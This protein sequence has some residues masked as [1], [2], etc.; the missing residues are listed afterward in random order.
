[1]SDTNLPDEGHH[2]ISPHHNA[3]GRFARGNQAGKGHG[4]PVA[5]ATI[6]LRQAM[7]SVLTP[8]AMIEVTLTHLDLIR[9]GPPK[10]RV[11]ALALLYDRLFGRA[12]ES[13][14]L[15]IHQTMPLIDASRYTDN[16]LGQILDLIEEPF[17]QQTVKCQVRSESGSVQYA[18]PQQPANPGPDQ[19]C[20][21]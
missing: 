9:N 12:K 5:T 13:I 18:V 17:R 7:L 11:E 14:E 1:M 15:D 6:K 4:S 20:Q 19:N 16:Q 2:P 10:V 21:R 8:E 3:S